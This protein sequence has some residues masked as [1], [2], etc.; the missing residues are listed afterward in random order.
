MLTHVVEVAMHQDEHG[1]IYV[2]NTRIPIDTI[3]YKFHQGSSPEDIVNSYPTLALSD[4]YAT[5]AYYL[6]HRE[7]VDTYLAQQVLESEKLQKEVEEQFP[8]EGMHAKLL[9]RL[10]DK[11]S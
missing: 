7:E 9:E 5:V 10:K 2:G 4:V 8:S 1:V 6:Q 11:R 3:I